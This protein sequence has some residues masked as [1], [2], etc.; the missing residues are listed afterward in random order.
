MASTHM[1]LFVGYGYRNGRPY[2]VFLNSNSKSF[3]DEGFK[4][5]YI[6]QIYTE[7]FYTLNAGTPNAS[8]RNTHHYQDASAS[9][10]ATR[11]HRLHLLDLDQHTH[12]PEPPPRPPPCTYHLHPLHRL[13]PGAEMISHLLHGRQVKSAVIDSQ[14]Q[15]PGALL[16]SP[17][18]TH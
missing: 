17:E 10:S 13:H 4:R 8:V 9:T 2:L 15:E 14:N 5:V 11:L 7:L 12:M 3:A 16:L 18:R 1:V 6:D